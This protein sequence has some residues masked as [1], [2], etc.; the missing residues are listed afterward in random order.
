MFR[1]S[2]LTLITGKPALNIPAVKLIKVN[3]HLKSKKN[4]VVNVD[5][6]FLYCR[7]QNLLEQP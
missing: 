4:Y 5:I 6:E 7:F 3:G 2:E 1:V